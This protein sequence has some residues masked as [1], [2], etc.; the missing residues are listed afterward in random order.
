MN[1]MQYDAE[2][3]VSGI[4]SDR[5][6]LL[7]NKHAASSYGVPVAV[8]A[9][10]RAYGP[11]DLGEPVAVVALTGRDYEASKRILSAARNAGF[12]FGIMPETKIDPELPWQIG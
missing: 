4:N 10:G 2:V 11:A 1:T 7:T 6:Y 8:D 5:E 12:I 9:Q 3:L